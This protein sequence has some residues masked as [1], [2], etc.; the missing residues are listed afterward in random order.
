MD[1]GQDQLQG[2]GRRRLP[3]P[4]GRDRVRDGQARDT[5][6]LR[7]A[8]DR[9]LDGAQRPARGRARTAPAGHPPARDGHHRVGAGGGDR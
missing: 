3:R 4:S 5:A 9:R 1:Q 2:A 6:H 8:A 7:A